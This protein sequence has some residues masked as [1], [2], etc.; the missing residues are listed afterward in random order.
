MGFLSGRFWGVAASHWY[1]PQ[2]W[3]WLDMG[4]FKKFSSL[5]VQTGSTSRPWHKNKLV[6]MSMLCHNFPCLLLTCLTLTYHFFISLLSS[7]YFQVH[8]FLVPFRML[9][10]F[11]LQRNHEEN[12]RIFIVVPLTLSSF[13]LSH[14]NGFQGPELLLEE[15]LFSLVQSLV[16]S[17]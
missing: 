8:T 5:S 14:H 17:F 16:G 12:T 3:G 1:H 13:V 15:M 9:L 10:S 6:I 11:L 2:S 4:M 7:L